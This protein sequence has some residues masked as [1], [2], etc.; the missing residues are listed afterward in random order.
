MDVLLRKSNLSDYEIIDEMLCKLHKYH[1]ENKPEVYKDIDY[2]FS[3]GEF[4][5]ILEE[6]NNFFILS[7]LDGVVV[8]LI[9]YRKAEKSNKFEKN[10]TQLWIDGLYVDE[11]YRNK[12][13]ADI[14]LSKVM[15]I[16]KNDSIDS[17]ESMVWDFN[18]ASKK[19]FAK[20]F[21][22]RASIMSYNV[23]L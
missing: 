13:I 11:R 10:R 8:G 14:L 1:V 2:F 9:W 21:E 6:N 23:K 3:K 18:E 4:E 7:I 15:D 17:I 16:A 5:K 12:G 19:L 20:Y 22:V